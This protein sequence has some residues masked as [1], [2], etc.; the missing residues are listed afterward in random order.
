MTALFASDQIRS[1]KAEAVRVTAKAGST[2]SW[3][4]KPKKNDIEVSALFV[5]TGVGM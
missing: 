1:G 2:F 5:A 3:Y 4:V